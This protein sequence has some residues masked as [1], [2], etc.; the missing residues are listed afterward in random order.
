MGS[1]GEPTPEPRRLSGRYELGPMLGYGGMAIVR[2]GTDLRLGRTVAVKVL[3]GELTEAPSFQARFRREARAAAALGHPAI[4]GIYDAGEEIIDGHAVLY[5]VMEYVDGHTLRQLLRTGPQP[6]RRALEITTEVLA[7]LAH[8]HRAGIVHRDI[9]PANVMVTRSGEV[10]VMDFGVARAVTDLSMS[11]TQTSAVVGTAH[12][13]S[14]EQARGERVDARSDVYSAGCLLF[15]L[16]TGRPPFEGDSAIA[17]AYQ[18]VREQ[19]Q[20]P[21]AY[22]PSVPAQVDAIV[23]GAL[24]K[25]PAERFQSADE[26]RVALLSFLAGDEPT[27]RAPAVDGTGVLPAVDGTGVLPAVPGPAS[28]ASRRRRNIRVLVAAGAVVVAA[29]LA[30]FAWSGMAGDPATDGGRQQAPVGGGQ[31]TDRSASPAPQPALEPAGSSLDLS[32]DG[33]PALET[34]G[35]DTDPPAERERSQ[36]ARP[37]GQETTDVANPTADPEPVDTPV[38][39]PAEETAPETTAPVESPP[40]ESPAPEPSAPAESPAPTASPGEE[41]AV[42]GSA[43]AAE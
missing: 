3:R 10:K 39:T 9:K 40:A 5:I 22:E 23:L 14:P 26:M 25:D 37:A 12:Y 7:A 8:S 15:E 33:D 13:L 1:A 32:E 42:S 36:D 11:L 29:A 28:A 34:E 24:A 35:Q 19:P 43:V 6:C 41:Q 17:V 38:A 27:A 20:P 21:S 30:G 4:V 2:R 31:P 18:H 16:L